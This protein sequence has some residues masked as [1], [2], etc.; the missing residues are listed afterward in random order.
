MAVSITLIL[1]AVAA[2]VLGLLRHRRKMAATF[3]AIQAE[4]TLRNIE[5]VKEN[6]FCRQLRDE[7]INVLRVNIEGDSS[8]KICI[9][10]FNRIS[11]FEQLNVVA[12]ALWN[13]GHGPVLSNRIDPW[14]WYKVGN[15]LAVPSVDHRLTKQILALAKNEQRTEVQISEKPLRIVGDYVFDMEYFQLSDHPLAQAIPDGVVEGMRLL[16]DTTRMVSQV[17]ESRQYQLGL[18]EIQQSMATPAYAKSPPSTKREFLKLREQLRYLLAVE[19]KALHDFIPAQDV[20]EA[21]IQ[22]RES[23]YGVSVDKS[24]SNH[25]MTSPEFYVLAA[26]GRAAKNRPISAEAVDLRVVESGVRKSF[27]ETAI[28]SEHIAHVVDYGKK[29]HFIRV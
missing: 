21:L 24:D 18:A 8:E 7:I 16:V 4:I 15:P 9:E 1:V 10:E 25:W 27:D 6:P 3:N 20:V 22:R 11:R 29:I 26:I 13:L 5:L 19:E 12:N 14:G 28:P 2:F 23:T 17:I